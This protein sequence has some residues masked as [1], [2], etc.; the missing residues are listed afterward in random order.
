MKL[1]KLDEKLIFEIKHKLTHQN[2]NIKFY[3][4][5]KETAEKFEKCF[6]VKV[7]DLDRYAFPKPITTFISEFL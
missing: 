6:W 1:D 3:E 7:K 2:L 5:G 4:T